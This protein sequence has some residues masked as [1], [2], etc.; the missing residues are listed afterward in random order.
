MALEATGSPLVSG[1]GFAPAAG[2][3]RIL[4]AIC[5]KGERVEVGAVVTLDRGLVSELIS[6]GK[7]E[8][9]TPP[10]EPENKPAKADKPK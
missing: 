10:K 5:V 8:R 2:Q 3:V 9:Y 4:R 6:A 1:G 7:A